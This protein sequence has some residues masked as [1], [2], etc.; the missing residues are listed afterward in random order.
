MVTNYARQDS[1]QERALWGWGMNQSSGIPQSILEWAARKLAESLWRAHRYG[2]TKAPASHVNYAGGRTNEHGKKGGTG[3]AYLQQVHC[4]WNGWE[5][6]DYVSPTDLKKALAFLQNEYGGRIV[7]I[8]LDFLRSEPNEQRKC[9]ACNKEE[10]A[11]FV[12]LQWYLLTIRRKIDTK[13]QIG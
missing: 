10:L 4:E 1:L 8:I 11:A 5:I 6:K 9:P 7:F 12:T 3:G 13:A 2:W